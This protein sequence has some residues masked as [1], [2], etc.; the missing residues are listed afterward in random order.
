MF[1][2]VDDV[3]PPPLAGEPEPVLEAARALLH[4]LVPLAL[5][6]LLAGLA[7]DLKCILAL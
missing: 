5:V 1:Y 6:V 3:V 2:L 4:Q 7:V